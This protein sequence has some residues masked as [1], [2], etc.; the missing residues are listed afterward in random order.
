MTLRPS[1]DVANVQNVLY[2][3]WKNHVFYVL[4]III[5]INSGSGVMTLRPSIDVANV[6]NVLYNFWKNHVFY[7]LFNIIFTER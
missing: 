5:F 6:Q 2:N 4:F 3:F 1:I 7:V